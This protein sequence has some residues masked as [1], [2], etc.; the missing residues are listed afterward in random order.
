LRITQAGKT[1]A[2][3][4]ALTVTTMQVDLED[5]INKAL[6]GAADLLNAI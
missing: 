3:G 6:Y 1:I 5:I 4:P 2:A